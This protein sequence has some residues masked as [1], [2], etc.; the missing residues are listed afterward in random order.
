MLKRAAAKFGA[1]Y[2]LDSTLDHDLR[3]SHVSIQRDQISDDSGTWFPLPALRRAAQR[4]RVGAIAARVHGV[5]TNRSQRHTLQ[6]DA[7]Q[8]LARCREDGADAAVL[9]PN[10]PVCHQTM[11]LVARTLEADGIATV[12]LGA[13]LDIIEHC[14][15]PRFVFSDV[16]LGNAA[17]LPHDSASQDATLERGLKLL[18]E[19]CAPRTTVHNPL[20]W[21]GDADWR[22][23]YMNPARLRA[24]ALAE[25]RRKFD[26][27]A[28]VTRSRLTPPS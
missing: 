22:D 3:V 8:V 9:V 26:A 19:A 27:Q 17:G 18:D 2:S 16:P 11:A 28:A 4:G 24:E 1:V 13:A 10:C 5:P 20:R 21:P 7:P 23:R 25:E 14:G 15:V 6:V 12:I